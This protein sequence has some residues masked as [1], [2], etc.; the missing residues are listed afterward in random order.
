MSILIVNQSV[1]DMCASCF[2]F[3]LLMDRE[4]TGLS[5]DSSY[6]QF[7]CRFWL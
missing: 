2:N 7:L 1:I 6:D 5:H 3:L 4:M